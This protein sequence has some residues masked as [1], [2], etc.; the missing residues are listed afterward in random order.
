MVV[1]SLAQLPSSG[2]VV[3]TLSGALGAVKSACRK[4]WRWFDVPVVTLDGQPI[5]EA[6]RYYFKAQPDVVLPFSVL[7]P[8]Y[9][10]FLEN[11]PGRPFAR[12]A[13]PFINIASGLWESEM[14]AD[15]F[16]QT[17]GGTSHWQSIAFQFAMADAAMCPEIVG[18]TVTYDHTIFSEDEFG[19]RNEGASASYT[20]DK[21]LDPLMRAVLKAGNH[22]GRALQDGGRWVIST[23]G[24]T[25]TEVERL[26]KHS[27]EVAAKSLDVP[28]P[29]VTPAR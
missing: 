8:E 7:T 25:S 17:M 22:I 14:A 16:A 1:P 21:E 12:V 18:E 15:G 11:D 6:Y 20:F 26:R 10:E 9:V 19:A 28:I 13:P 24:C 5:R 4:K 27:V 3:A 29:K 2:K 23:F